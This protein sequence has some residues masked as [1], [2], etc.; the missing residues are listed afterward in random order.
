MK[1][2]ERAT[3]TLGE[4]TRNLNR[5]WLK[6]SLQQEIMPS[7]K[8]SRDCPP[9]PY[10][11][12]SILLCRKVLLYVPSGESDILY[13]NFTLPKM[14][15]MEENADILSLSRKGYRC[16]CWETPVVEKR[17]SSVIFPHPPNC[18]IPDIPKGIFQHCQVGCSHN[19]PPSTY[20]SEGPEVY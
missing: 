13:L 17:C 19:C 7:H 14:Q 15:K 5:C 10:S 16:N 2:Q 6:R 18:S 9:N 12:M 1:L 3:C 8:N 4:S 20:A 11:L